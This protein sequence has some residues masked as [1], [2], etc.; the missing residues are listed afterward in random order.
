MSCEADRTDRLNDVSRQ[1]LKHRQ[2]IIKTVLFRRL[3]VNAL[4]FYFCCCGYI[5]FIVIPDTTSIHA[6]HICTRLSPDVRKPILGVSDQS[7][8]KPGWAITEYG[9]RLRKKRDCTIRV[10]K[11]K[12][13]VSFVVTAKLICVFVF[14]Y[15][16]IRFS[17]VASQTVT[18]P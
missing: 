5:V 11:T 15:A 3:F 17:H 9:Y 7:R 12:K 1:C 6:V 14:A 18:W 2:D 13:L 4:S 8:H 16:K 10:A